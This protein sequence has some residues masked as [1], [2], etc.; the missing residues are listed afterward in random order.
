MRWTSGAT[1][2]LMYLADQAKA[3]FV[4]SDCDNGIMVSLNQPLAYP[5]QM[6]HIPSFL[7][8]HLMNQNTD[9]FLHHVILSGQYISLDTI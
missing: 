7:S 1:Q 3:A 6:E 5:G 4:D 9:T 2:D 8:Y